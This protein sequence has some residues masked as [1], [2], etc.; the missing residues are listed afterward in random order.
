M[1]EFFVWFTDIRHGF[2][3]IIQSSF[4]QIDFFFVNFFA[5]VIKIY[6]CMWISTTVLALKCI[7][8]RKKK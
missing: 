7:D 6:I 1:F 2:R 8:F 3:Y 5:Q 4:M